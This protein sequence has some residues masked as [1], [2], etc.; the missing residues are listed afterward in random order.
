MNQRRKE[1]GY[2]AA[3]ILQHAWMD[4]CCINKFMHTNQ[5]MHAARC[6]LHASCMQHALMMH[7]AWWI[8]HASIHAC[9][10][11]HVAHAAC[12]QDAHCNNACMHAC[13]MLH[14]S[15]IM[16]PSTQLYAILLNFLSIN[17]IIS[18]TI[19]DKLI[20][21]SVIRGGSICVTSSLTFQIVFCQLYCNT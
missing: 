21:F 14:P 19:R 11:M 3:R 7:G 12:I 6:M 10:K 8:H 13:C 5:F 2:L 1:I 20:P 15:C 4:A 16:H 18:N 17:C 9:G